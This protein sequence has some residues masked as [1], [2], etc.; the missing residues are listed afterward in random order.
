MVRLALIVS[1][2]K[3]FTLQVFLGILSANDKTPVKTFIFLEF[4]H[5]IN[6]TKLDYLSNPSFYIFQI[7]DC[8]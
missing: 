4:C 5:K 2:R 6:K 8:Y 3:Y 7:Q 1:F